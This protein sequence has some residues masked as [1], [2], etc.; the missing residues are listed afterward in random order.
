[1]FW[2][3]P[4]EDDDDD[5]DDD[6]VWSAGR[7]GHPRADVPQRALGVGVGLQG[8]HGRR[9][10]AHPGVLLP[11]RLPEQ[12]Q[13]H[14]AGSDDTQTRTRINV[15]RIKNVEFCLLFNKAVDGKC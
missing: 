2:A 14:P 7:V 5:D 13:P 3:L 15:R 1:M 6:D 8:Q 10:G 4:G 9:P 12:L 11:A